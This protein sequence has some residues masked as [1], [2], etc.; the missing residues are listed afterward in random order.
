MWYD[1]SHYLVGLLAWSL[2]AYGNSP[3]SLEVHPLERGT[4]TL[5][6]VLDE[7]ITQSLKQAPSFFL[8]PQGYIGQMESLNFRGLTGPHTYVVLDGIGL[9]DMASGQVDLSHFLNTGSNQVRVISGPEVILHTNQAAGLLYADTAVGEE[10]TVGFLETGSFKTV[11]T[12][13]RST[14]H[15]VTAIHTLM[16][17][18]QETAGLSSYGDQRRYGERNRYTNDNGGLISQFQVNPALSLK[19]HARVINSTLKYDNGLAPLPPKPQATQNSMISLLGSEITYEGENGGQQLVKA[20]YAR[21]AMTYEPH[22]FSLNQEVSLRYF[23][24]IQWQENKTQ[25]ACN[26][27]SSTLKK[28]EGFKKE[29]SL[30]GLSI[31]HSMPFMKDWVVEIGGRQEVVSHYKLAPCGTAGIAWDRGNTKLYGSWRHA[32]RLPTLYDL[33]G[34]SAFFTPNAS[35]KKE[36]MHLWELGWKQKIQ[37][38]GVFQVVYFY[39]HQKSMIIWVPTSSFSST[40]SNLTH[41]AVLQGI[42]TSL[43][44]EVGKVVLKGTYVYTHTRYPKEAMVK[45]PVPMHRGSLQGLCPFQVA[46]K[47]TMEMEYIGCRYQGKTKMQRYLLGNIELSYDLNASWRVYGQVK[48]VGNTVYQTVP[49]YRAAKRACYVGTHFSF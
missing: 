43:Q 10:K 27:V 39:N 32:I 6:Q 23:Q 3:L 49:G 24:T 16:A 8:K 28:E 14:F 13:V 19:T 33:Y 41:S 44:H 36:N 48:N 17:N 11:G 31:L 4:G 25:W 20:E 37:D 5:Y 2:N 45:P 38:S 35:L 34:E 46:W 21:Q 29:R 47:I 12:G 7:N 30:G 18:H 42:E 40:V 9:N 1:K 22:S 15:T 26:L